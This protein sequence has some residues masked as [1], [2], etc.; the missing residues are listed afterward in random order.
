VDCGRGT[1][2][3]AI[4]RDLG[5]MLGTGGHLTQLR[6]TR[7]GPFHAADAVTIERLRADG[8]TPHLSPVPG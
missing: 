6:R 4:A 1:Y 5:E 7:I 3:R 2:V 8:A